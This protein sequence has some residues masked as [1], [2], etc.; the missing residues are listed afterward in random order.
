MYMDSVSYSFRSI[1]FLTDK[2]LKTFKLSFHIYHI[3]TG[4]I[5]LEIIKLSHNIKVLQS[6]YNGNK[7]NTDKVRRNNTIHKSHDEW[8]MWLSW[9]SN[10]TY[11]NN[12]LGMPTSWR[13]ISS[14]HKSNTSDADSCP[15]THLKY[16][17]FLDT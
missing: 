2:M 4:H 15:D 14:D 16:Y 5:Y 13:L 7:R 9:I 10:D 1:S 3:I 8:W 12:G 6:S 17:G 11:L